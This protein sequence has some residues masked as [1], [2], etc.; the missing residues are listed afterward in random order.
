M[1]KQSQQIKHNETHRGSDMTILRLTSHWFS[2]TML[3]VVPY[4]YLK[5]GCSQVRVSL[6]SDITSNRTRRN[7]LKLC[8]RR[9]KSDIRKNSKKVVGCPGGHRVTVPGGVQEPHRCG[10]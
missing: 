1:Q 4:N 2:S 8:Y 7:G 9:V 6:F 10:T 5:G 3:L